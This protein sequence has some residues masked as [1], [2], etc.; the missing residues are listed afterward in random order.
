MELQRSHRNGRKVLDT[1][2]R[3][4]VHNLDQTILDRIEDFKARA[5]I[6]TDERE[7]AS[8]TVDA[9]TTRLATL[10][11]QFEFA[12]LGRQ[13]AAA[14]YAQGKA[15]EKSLSGTMQATLRASERAIQARQAVEQLLGEAF[16]L[17]QGLLSGASSSEQLVVAVE[18]ASS[19]NSYIPAE[20]L[21]AAKS[22]SGAASTALSSALQAFADVSE[23]LTACSRAET[24]ALLVPY[25]IGNF[26]E[27]FN[28]YEVPSDSDILGP[29]NEVL[30][31]SNQE[32]A[33][34]DASAGVA[35]PSDANSGSTAP[36]TIEELLSSIDASTGEDA[37]KSTQTAYRKFA[38]A[39]RDMFSQSAKEV[40]SQA[41]SAFHFALDHTAAGSPEAQAL[42]ILGKLGVLR[43]VAS[44]Q[45]SL[46]RDAVTEAE[47]HLAMAKQELDR[48]QLEFQLA[49]SA[50]DAAE[51]AAM[52]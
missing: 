9:L 6:A 36:E 52:T 39:F 35:A 17:C 1:H 2:M 46:Y 50:K 42:G 12:Q 22:A 29:P 43:D 37:T 13:T 23:A 10:Q 18:R 5:V 34:T 49:E 41:L 14:N 31:S 4:P 24:A 15:T 7:V 21:V 33:S 20:L 45:E 48:K 32:D 19:K 51:H 28:G 38:L 26:Q 25:S 16:A 44:A 47:G 30:A 8:A 27:V 40:P 11:G 3:T